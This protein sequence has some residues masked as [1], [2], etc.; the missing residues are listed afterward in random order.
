MNLITLLDEPVLDFAH[1]Q[2]AVDPHDG[3]AIFGSYDLDLP[4][5]S[6]RHIVIGTEV[7][8]ELWKGWAKAVNRGLGVSDPQKHRLWPPYPGFEVCF[9]QRWPELPIR[10]FTIDRGKILSASRLQDAHARAFEVVAHFRDALTSA[11]KL[12]SKPSVAVCILPDEVW[13][14]C[15]PQSRIIEPVGPSISNAE[16]KARIAGQMDLFDAFDHTQYRLSV[17]FR[18]Q[19]KA[20]AMEFEIP[21]QIILESTLRL[22]DENKWKERHLTPLSDRMWNLA[23]TLHYKCGGKPWKLSGVRRGVCYVGIAFKR[24]PY[25]D[26][27]ACCAAQMFLDSG[28]GIVFLG[29]FGPWYSSKDRQFHLPRS[30]AKKLL[31]GVLDTYNRVKSPHDPQIRE[32]FIHS[33][34][35]IDEDEFQGYRDACPENCAIVGIRVRPDRDGPRVFRN[36][37]MPIRRGTCL[38][39]DDKLG[40]LFSTGFKPRLATYDGWEVPVP[41]KIDIQ[42]GDANI[43]HVMKDILALTKLNYN[44]CRLGDGQPVTV[45]FSDAVG[46]ILISNPA[47]QSGKPNFKYYI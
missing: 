3:L 24:D 38:V 11:L 40:Y 27:T 10:A 13:N 15:R 19:L 31:S 6:H 45:L 37:E 7:G 26:L 1:G 4:P 8:L 12:D 14:N 33:R 2:V 20:R 46:E 30:E 23:T 36:G 42:H 5:V 47:I 43:H 29:D 28:D 16:R 17:D 32:I 21:V 18:R 39:V 25:D 35:L 41:L 9:G 44:A 22:S 34:S